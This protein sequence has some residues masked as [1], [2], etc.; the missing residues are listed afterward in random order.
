MLGQVLYLEAEAA[1]TVSAAFRRRRIDDDQ[2]VAP[3]R[4][5][6]S[7]THHGARLHAIPPGAETDGEG[8]IIISLAGVGSRIRGDL[9][10]RTHHR[11]CC[12]RLLKSKAD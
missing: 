7:L 4:R 3:N 10:R 9:L 1:G 11:F 6:L 8:D 12:S 2:T 5:R